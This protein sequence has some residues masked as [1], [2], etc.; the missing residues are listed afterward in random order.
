MRIDMKPGDWLVIFFCLLLIPLTWTL[1]GH[2]SGKASSVTVMVDDQLQ[3]IYP[4]Y[5]DKR[6]T[7][8]NG[9]ARAVIE[10]RDSKVRFVSSNCP[11]KLCVLSG[12]HYHGGDDIVCL[13]NRIVVSL[14]SDNDRYDAINF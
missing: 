4:I 10:I 12:W 5:R 2:G 9:A 14:Q 13:P 8:E 3:G 11:S 6:I 7:I 1:G